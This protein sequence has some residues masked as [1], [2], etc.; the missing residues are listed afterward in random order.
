[1]HFLISY[2]LICSQICPESRKKRLGDQGRSFTCDDPTVTCLPARQDGNSTSCFP[3]YD[4]K[5]WFPPLTLR[6]LLCTVYKL[7]ELCSSSELWTK[8]TVNLCLIFCCHA[9]HG[10]FLFE[11]FRLYTETELT[12]SLLYHSFIIINYSN[13]Q[14][15]RNFPTI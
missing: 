2:V 3:F 14:V 10:D 15:L 4:I 5:K 7:S 1:M 13:M 8:H 11:R 12:S 9:K 6:F